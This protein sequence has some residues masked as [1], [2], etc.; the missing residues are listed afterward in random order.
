M[1]YNY[2]LLDIF[3]LILNQYSFKVIPAP[4][5]APIIIAKTALAL[6]GSM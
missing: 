2:D 1:L 6:P 4:A 5:I 3:S